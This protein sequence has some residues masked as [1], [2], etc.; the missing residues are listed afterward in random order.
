MLKVYVKHIIQSATS[1][2]PEREEGIEQEEDSVD[3]RQRSLGQRDAAGVGLDEATLPVLDDHDAA[4]EEEG[5]SDQ[6]EERVNGL[7]QRRIDQIA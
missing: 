6:A 7:V 3:D 2:T 4:R 5:T 1:L